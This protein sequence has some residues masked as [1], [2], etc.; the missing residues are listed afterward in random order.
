LS[1]IRLDVE[2]KLMADGHKR[3]NNAAKLGIRDMFKESVLP[4]AREYSPKRTDLSHGPVT[5]G[6][7]AAS[8]GIRIRSRLSRIRASIFTASGYGGY[9]EKGTR[10]MGAR[11]YLYPALQES[12]PALFGFLRERFAQL[13]ELGGD[14]PD[15]LI[16]GIQAGLKT[17]ADKGVG[18][19]GASEAKKKARHR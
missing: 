19:I 7:N 18:I 9:L 11:P 10:K 2:I 3:F 5:P 17:K 16:R 12:L 15:E 13:A 14:V 1:P 4:L 8:I 6:A